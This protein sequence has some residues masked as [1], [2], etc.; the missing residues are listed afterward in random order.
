MLLIT[1]C[2]PSRSR[3]RPRSDVTRAATLAPLRSLLS[4]R[5]LV[6]WMHSPVLIFAF[7]ARKPYGLRHRLRPNRK[8][9]VI[10][11]PFR[12]ERP[13]RFFELAWKEKHCTSGQLTKT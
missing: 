4:P 11:S 12:R 1:V 9:D 6:A 7:G 13:W 3:M 2:I 8:Q 10:A 5:I